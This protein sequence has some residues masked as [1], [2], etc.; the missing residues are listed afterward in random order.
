MN[1][2]RVRSFL[3]C[4]NPRR[5]AANACVILLVVFWVVP[6]ARELAFEYLGRLAGDPTVIGP[7]REWDK[8]TDPRE[9]EAYNFAHSIQLPDSL[10]KPV[11]FN[12]LRYWYL[13]H[14]RVSY[15]YFQHLC[16][17]EAGE[18]IFKTVDKVEGL[19]QM[20]PMPKRTEELMKDRYGFEDPADWS[21]GEAD[22]SPT[23]F[24]GGPEN[25]FIY[26]E[27]QV[28]PRNIVNSGELSRWNVRSNGLAG[29]RLFW[30]YHS[31][32]YTNSI[33]GPVAD[34]ETELSAR[35]GYTWRGIRREQDRMYGISGGELI[36]LDVITHDIL[37]V[38]RTFAIAKVHAKVGLRW[39]FSYFCPGSLRPIRQERVVNKLYYPF[40]FIFQVLKPINF[41][42]SGH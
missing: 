32:D 16:N 42:A 29:D 33:R 6:P 14:G 3:N 31:Y 2:S 27:S 4:R 17:T 11:P 38:R 24:I 37:A 28:E 13:D 36:I 40:S 39:E 30:R 1:L 21:Q 23:L 41:R 35:Y 5:C 8:P 19:Y 25:G 7:W 26:F 34:A 12:F 20:R 15:E 18:Y 22:G 10:P 9:L